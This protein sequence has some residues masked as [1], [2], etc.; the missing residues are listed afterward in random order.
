MPRRSGVDGRELILKAL[1]ESDKP[2]SIREL[3]KLTGLEW[4]AIWYW[5]RNRNNDN[6]LV[7]NGC[8]V[9]IRN[10][11]YTLNRAQDE[12]IYALSKFGKI[13]CINQKNDKEENLKKS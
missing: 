13:Y 4:N 7:K 11:D 3:Q 5:L 10:K 8:V 6:N 9:E 2:L 1:I 12:Y